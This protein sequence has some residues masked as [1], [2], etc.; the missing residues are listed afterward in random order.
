V[1]DVVPTSLLEDQN[2]IL[3]LAR[4]ADGLLDEAQVR[5][6]YYLDDNTWKALGANEPLIAKIEAEKER[7]I[8]DGSSARERAQKHF[9]VA[10]DILGTIMRDPQAP[11]RNRIE[12][13]KELRV[14]ADNGPQ[15][16][17]AAAAGQFLIQIN[18]G[19]GEIIQYPASNDKPNKL[20]D[21][22]AKVAEHDT[23]DTEQLALPWGAFL[24]TN[25][26][27]G[28]GNGSLPV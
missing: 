8:R 13:A 20:L 11:A 10:P 17:P 3:T 15:M 14:V 21:V 18:L 26:Q 16:A 27:G 22:S 28:G 25:K 1:G 12:S 5:K 4:F 6:R 24:V 2:F 9:A 19:G 7:R 23:D